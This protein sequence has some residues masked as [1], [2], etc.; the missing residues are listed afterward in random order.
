MAL[1]M[2]S[3]SAKSV[4]GSRADLKER[5]PVA[6]KA[7]RAPV[8]VKAQQQDAVSVLPAQHSASRDIPAE[9]AANANRLQA[10]SRRAALGA[11]A[12][13]AALVSRTGPS[14][15]A[16]GDAANVFGRTTNK[17]GISVNFA[18]AA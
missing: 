3:L 18:P 16:F 4:L 17:S 12:G 9:T 15:A 13:V 7:I 5:S 11:L 2:H 6:A 14:E 1:S 10:M 8:L